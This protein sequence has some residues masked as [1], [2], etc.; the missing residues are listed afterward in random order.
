[1]SY[2]SKRG[3]VDPDQTDDSPQPE[4]AQ[5]QEISVIFKKLGDGLIFANKLVKADGT[6]TYIPAKTI[7][8][9][10]AAGTYDGTTFTRAL[11]LKEESNNKITIILNDDD[12]R[13][14]DL[15]EINKTGGAK[16]SRKPKKRV[17]RRRRRTMNKK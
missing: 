8:D 5:E 17:H 9:N 10:T 16:K 2:E 1:M 3:V 4:N 15:G 7:V 11:Q 14:I 12:S 13:E 6:V